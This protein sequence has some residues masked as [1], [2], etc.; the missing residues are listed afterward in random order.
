MKV[1]VSVA[2]AMAI[3]AGSGVAFADSGD[4]PQFDLPQPVPATGA[5]TTTR[6]VTASPMSGNVNNEGQAVFD[7]P[8]ATIDENGGGALLAAK[9]DAA[10]LQTANSA[11]PGFGV[12]TVE[13]AARATQAAPQMVTGR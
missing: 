7:G 12:D 13:L 8:L 6:N 2:T 10:P 1:L 4:G 11:P 9:G 3:V 5:V